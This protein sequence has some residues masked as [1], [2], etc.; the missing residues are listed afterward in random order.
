MTPNIVLTY[1]SYNFSKLYND[2]KLVSVGGWEGIFFSIKGRLKK[3][4]IRL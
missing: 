2:F 1:E 4:E 3:S